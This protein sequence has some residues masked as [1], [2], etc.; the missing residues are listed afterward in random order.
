MSEEEGREEG[1]NGV[2]GDKPDGK[3][4]FS[5]AGSVFGV[6]N[7]M[8]TCSYIKREISYL[9]S[10]LLPFIDTKRPVPTLAFLQLKEK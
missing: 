5:R 1:N 2:L 9:F 7:I 6:Q 10:L 3:N 8:T 4:T